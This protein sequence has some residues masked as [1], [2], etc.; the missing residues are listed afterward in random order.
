MTA[1]RLL[2]LFLHAVLIPF[3]AWRSGASLDDEGEA[4]PRR[5]LYLSVLVQQVVLVGI[6]LLAAWWLGV[7]LFPALDP[8]PLDL[9][10]GVLL[11]SISVGLIVPRWKR[12]REEDR[13]RLAAF[14]PVTPE[15][16]RLW[17][18][19]SLCAGVGEEITYRGVLWAVWE[20]VLGGQHLLA[21]L[22]ASVC[23][24][25]AHL[26]Q[27]WRGAGVVF[28]FA[29]AFH[30]LVELTGSLYVAMA[31]HFAHDLAAGRIYA[32]LI[33]EG[34]PARADA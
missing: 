29:L 4:P 13:R 28:V 34:D 1:V 3:A 7:A 24:A 6:S 25:L 19:L 16:H 23:F 26:T 8:E 2:F 27:G 20:Q 15:D 14:M 32:R 17:V 11:V 31:V 21:A 30:G 5:D 10:A 22:A 18:L 33:R 9:V 12:A